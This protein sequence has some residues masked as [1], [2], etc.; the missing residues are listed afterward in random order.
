MAASPLPALLLLSLLACG[1]CA[2]PAGQRQEVLAPSNL[3]W[4]SPIAGCQ[5]FDCV[6]QYI[7]LPDD[8]YSWTDT[9][10]RLYGRAGATRHGLASMS[11]TGY[12]LNL[13]SQRWRTGARVDHPLWWHTLVV[14]VPEVVEFS[15]WATLNLDFGW[16]RNGSYV[17]RIDNREASYGEEHVVAIDGNS[18]F[19]SLPTLKSAVSEAA[20]LAT[21]TRA[22]AATLLNL[23]N[24]GEVFQDDPLQLDRRQD[25]LKA[26]S[27]QDFL[28]H[29]S[30][31]ERIMELP[32]AKAAVRA[33]DAVQ[34]FTELLRP[35][36]GVRRFGVTGYS[37]LGTATYVAAAADRRVKAIVPVAIY[38][39][40]GDPTMNYGPRNPMVA[41]ELRQQYSHQI[42]TNMMDAYAGTMVSMSTPE[43]Q[44][45]GSIIDPYSFK[46]RLNLPKLVILSSGDTVISDLVNHQMVSH[47]SE[48]PGTT[49]YLHVP[50]AVH[51]GV[52]G[53][54]LASNAAFF[55]GHLLGLTP[56]AVL[57]EWQGARQILRATQTG[58]TDL[59]PLAAR[60]W[61]GPQ[62]NGQGEWTST[63][64]AVPAQGQLTW[65]ARVPWHPF[66]PHSCF[67]ELIFEWPEPG[68]Y[69]HTS[70][71]KFP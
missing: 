3:S 53:S 71:Q 13:T 57:S 62:R 32:I 66:S 30:E 33:M 19:D 45:L 8:S 40:L 28:D 41:R 31:P 17:E 7:S 1:L 14:I 63:H 65:S 68:Q 70:S 61:E 37:K 59:R 12:V 58:N 50:D 43:F 21:R 64:L 60:R 69:Y 42:P 67:I 23:P 26:F 20:V 29:P 55:R 10:A 36:A 22:L 39:S 5:G 11:W 54:S 27:Y 15:D 34:A 56:P 49:G 48:L 52:F 46:E 2:A 25:F 35:G 51:D 4:V 9:Q 47:L 44:K 24:D 16:Q 6:L 18:L 38:L